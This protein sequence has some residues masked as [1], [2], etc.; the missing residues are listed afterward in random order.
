M[1]FSIKS[2][3]IPLLKRYEEQLKGLLAE[4]A[5]RIAVLEVQ[6]HL[7]AAYLHGQDEMASSVLHDLRN[8]LNPLVVRLGR[9]R[10]QVHRPDSNNFSQ[11][12]S[13]LRSEELDTDRK[14]KLLLY[15]ERAIEIL[16][17][18]RLQIL[19]QV[20]TAHEQVMQ[21]EGLL[22]EFQESNYRVSPTEAIRIWDIFEDLRPNFLELVQSGI[23]IDVDV[24]IRNLPIVW[25]KR[26][27]LKQVF[28]NLISNSRDA[29]QEAKREDGVLIVAGSVDIADRQS[30]VKLTF[31]DNGCGIPASD[32][33]RIFQRG[34]S[35]K[36][37]AINGKGLHW[38]ANWINEIGGQISA[39]SAGK[40]AGVRFSILL[41]TE[42][43]SISR[44]NSS[45]AGAQ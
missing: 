44:M 35:T 22:K 40:G 14:E 20:N 32:I 25:A 38:C 13:E 7:E 29:I 16:L 36:S 41:P 1:Y 15:V 6:Q 28:L 39:S 37:P 27:P 23:T 3:R 43:H 9:L 11:A 12:L 5:A 45:V 34:F 31:E 19:E 24:S 21:T 30:F 26:F 10:G 8:L 4:D 33:S 42:R 17:E 18:E 2:S